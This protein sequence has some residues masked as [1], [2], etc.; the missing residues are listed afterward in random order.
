LDTLLSSLPAELLAK[1]LKPILCSK[2]IKNRLSY[3]NDK[4][5][6]F[7][8]RLC[9]DIGVR[10]VFA[11]RMMPTIWIDEL[12]K[13]GGF[14]LIFKYQLYPLAQ[15]GLVKRIAGELGLPV[16]TPRA[17]ADG[18]MQRFLNWHQ[19]NVN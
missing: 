8:I 14:A 19:K 6:K 2:I 17:L 16:D 7:K 10:P 13:A 9:Q 5:F 12:V 11:V 3:I 15:R 18:T 4:E 1:S